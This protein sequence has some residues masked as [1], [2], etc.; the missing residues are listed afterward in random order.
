MSTLNPLMV[1]A[2][3]A[4]ERR[5]SGQDAREVFPRESVAVMVRTYSPTC[6][7][8]LAAM[9]KALKSNGAVTIWLVGSVKSLERSTPF[10]VTLV[11]KETEPVVPTVPLRVKRVGAAAWGAKASKIAGPA[12]WAVLLV[13]VGVEPGEVGVLSHPLSQVARPTRKIMALKVRGVLIEGLSSMGMADQC[14]AWAAKVGEKYLPVSA[15][16]RKKKPLGTE[17]PRGSSSNQKFR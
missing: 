12:F 10:K 15:S 6:A 9:V 17:V 1:G 5:E 11:H 8:L 13:S 2:A 16:P 4:F 14:V 7:V 3:T